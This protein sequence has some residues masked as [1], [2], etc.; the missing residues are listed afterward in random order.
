MPKHPDYE[1]DPELRYGYPVQ[2][3]VV[4]RYGSPEAIL[5]FDFQNEELLGDYPPGIEVYRIPSGVYDIHVAFETFPVKT[6]D[7]YR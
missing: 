7:D 4:Y 1:D 3:Y 2:F 6:A 5:S